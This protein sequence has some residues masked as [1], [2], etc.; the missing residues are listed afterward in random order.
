MAHHQDIVQIRFPRAVG[1][2]I[3]TNVYS[4]NETE[5]RQHRAGL[6]LVLVAAVVLLGLHSRGSFHK[7]VQQ[8]SHA[9][10]RVLL[11]RE[12]EILYPPWASFEL[13]WGP[14]PSH[15][16]ATRKGRSVFTSL[17]RSDAPSWSCAKKGLH[18]RVRSRDDEFVVSA[19]NRFKKTFCESGIRL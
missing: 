8:H 17:V 4:E 9:H 19:Q 14:A 11:W 18:F 7:I 6:Y 2:S 5:A 16:I 12:Q 15:A 13:T 1:A 3:I 10:L